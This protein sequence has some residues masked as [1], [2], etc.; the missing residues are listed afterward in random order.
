VK[1]VH[2]HRQQ[3]GLLRSSNPLKKA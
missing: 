3:G 2:N 1:G